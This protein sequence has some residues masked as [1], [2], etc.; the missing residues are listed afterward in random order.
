[1]IE[2]KEGRISSED[3]GLAGCLDRLTMVL[4][5]SYNNFIEG[6]QFQFRDLDLKNG[7]GS[8][9]MSGLEGKGS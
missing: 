6:S 2:Q 8:S 9:L 7:Q 1:M 5:T 3:H 4:T